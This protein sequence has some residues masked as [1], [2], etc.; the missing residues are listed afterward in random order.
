[1]ATKTKKNSNAPLSAE[2]LVG[3]I[4]DEQLKLKKL[5]FSHAITPIENPLTIRATK[6]EIARLKTAQRRLQ[7]GF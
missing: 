6:K 5:Q 4:S 2:E 7:L 3:R 1:M